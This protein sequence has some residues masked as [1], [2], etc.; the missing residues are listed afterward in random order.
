MLKQTAKRLI[1]YVAPKPWRISRAIFGA[2]NIYVR[3]AKNLNYDMT[4]NGELH[5]LDCLS[6]FDFRT[7]F[8]VGANRGDYTRACLE[9][10]PKAHI[11]AFEIAPKTFAALE[12]AVADCERIT[13]NAFGLSDRAGH[14][15]FNYNTEL[16]DLSTS[17]DATKKL[18]ATGWQTLALPIITGD[19]YCSNHAISHVDLLKMDVE[20]A[21][22]LVL[23]GFRNMLTAGNIAAIQFEYGMVNIYTKFLLVDFWSLLADYGYVL[24]PIMPRGV[25]FR[26]YDPMQEDFLG[27]PNFLAVQSSK[28]DLIK[29]LATSG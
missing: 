24:G 15:Q 19:E 14:I 22:H 12:A 2:A 23:A 7:V 1:R 13:L 3:A 20:G 5:V 26:D 11:H 6:S 21:E 29:A 8:D 27:P 28:R 4:S 25:V 9:R 18:H 16:D 10:L 17:F